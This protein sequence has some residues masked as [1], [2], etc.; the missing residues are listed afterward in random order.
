MRHT[1]MIS[2]LLAASL[3]VSAFPVAP[4]V[5][6]VEAADSFTANYGEALQGRFRTGTG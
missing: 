1:R 5:V 6:S 2:L 3:A 4:A